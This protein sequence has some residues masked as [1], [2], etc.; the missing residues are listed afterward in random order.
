VENVMEDRNLRTRIS[1]DQLEEM[2][3]ELEPRFLA[4]LTD[5]L[6][7]AGESGMKRTDGVN[8]QPPGVEHVDLIVL[9]GIF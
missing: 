2:A 4:P 7:M 5:A 3:R 9:M 1:R 6:R 8:D